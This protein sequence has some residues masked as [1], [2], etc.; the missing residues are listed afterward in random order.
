MAHP[1][2]WTSSCGLCGFICYTT[3]FFCFWW[4]FIRWT[5]GVT[6]LW[7]ANICNYGTFSEATDLSLGAHSPTLV[8][9]L[10]CGSFLP[11]YWLLFWSHSYLKC[12]TLHAQNVCAYSHLSWSLKTNFHTLHHS[13]DEPALVLLNVWTDEALFDNSFKII[14]RPSRPASFSL[15]LIVKSAGI[16]SPN[17]RKCLKTLHPLLLPLECVF[18]SQR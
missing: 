6:G 14:T 11:L 16:N 18:F 2:T 9:Y 1:T 4:K 3:S 7:H 12:L 17:F 10:S 5:F 8:F 15:S 13:S